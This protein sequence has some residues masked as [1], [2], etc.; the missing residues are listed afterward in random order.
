MSAPVTVEARPHDL[1]LLVVGHGTDVEQVVFDGI[2]AHFTEQ[3][4]QHVKREIRRNAGWDDVEKAAICDYESGE[5]PTAARDLRL[6]FEVDDDTLVVHDR[7]TAARRV[8]HLVKTK[9]RNCSVAGMEF[10]HAI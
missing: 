5:N 10:V 3:A 6:F 4:R 7:N 2:A 8:G 9:G 1:C